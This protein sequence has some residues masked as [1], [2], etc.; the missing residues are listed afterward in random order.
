MGHSKKALVVLLLALPILNM[1][2]ESHYILTTFHTYFFHE[3]NVTQ[4]EV[5]LAPVRERLKELNLSRLSH[6]VDPGSFWEELVGDYYLV[7]YVL[8]PVA[9][10]AGAD[11]KPWV[12]MNYSAVGKRFPAPDLECIEDF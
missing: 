3:D 2:L 7:Q 10:H 4:M 5:A 9:L 8:A 11:E 6:R 1:G 12:L